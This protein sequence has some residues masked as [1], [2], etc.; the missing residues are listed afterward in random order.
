M[1]IK[2][3][4]IINSK[5]NKVYIGG[6]IKLLRYRLSNHKCRKRPNEPLYK[7]MTEI[8]RQYFS[9]ILL[10]EKEVDSKRDLLDLEDKYIDEFRETNPEDCLNKNR[11]Y[12]TKKQKKEKKHLN[13]LKHKDSQYKRQRDKITK[14]IESQDKYDR[15]MK[16]YYQQNK[17]KW[18]KNNG[19]KITCECGKEVSKAN[20]KRHKNSSLHTRLLSL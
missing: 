20:F 9:I 12:T 3:Y 4:K 14:D 19:I 18:Q 5:N 10:E 16:N 11:A 2:I 6:T 15:E 7:L 8:G 17:S 1:K 13:Y